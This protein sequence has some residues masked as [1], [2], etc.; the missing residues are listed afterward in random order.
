MVEY[1]AG[2]DAIEAM[3]ATTSPKAKI[4]I[5]D[6]LAR[7]R[8]NLRTVIQLTEDLE[9]VGEAVN[10]L[11]AVQLAER[12]SPDIVLM[13]LEMPG[14]DGFEATHQIKNRHLAKGVIMLTIHG[15]DEA[16]GRAARMGVDAFVEKATGVETLL[17]TIRHVWSKL[18]LAKE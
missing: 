5:V 14:L 7:V 10:G 12:L 18:S 15:H 6:D 16:R 9:V 17:A 11:E 8:Q 13:D 3:K 1:K 4:L 2:E